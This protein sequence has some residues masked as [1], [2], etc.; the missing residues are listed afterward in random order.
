MD[1]ADGRSRL[2]KRIIAT[3]ALDSVIG[4]VRIAADP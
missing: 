3:I 4:A 2:Q 1:C